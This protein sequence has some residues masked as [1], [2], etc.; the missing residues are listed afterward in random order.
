VNF[1]EIIAEAQ[2]G[3]IQAY[4]PG[5]R[6]QVVAGTGLTPPQVQHRLRLMHADGQVHIGSYVRALGTGGRFSPVFHDG[7][8]TDVEC[9]LK[10][11]DDKIYSR[12]W[13][14]VHRNDEVMEKK[15]ATDRQRHWKKKAKRGDKLV[16]A[17]FGR[18]A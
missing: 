16:N 17:L 7:P 18:A 2:R 14:K 12:R 11:Q 1:F 4:L 13:R 9:R 15:R 8:G 5:T 6:A 3:A 10:A